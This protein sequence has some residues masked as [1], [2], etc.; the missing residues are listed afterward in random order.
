MTSETIHI[1]RHRPGQTPLPR[2][3]LW[4]EFGTVD[5]SALG[6]AAEPA[7]SRPTVSSAGATGVGIRVSTPSWVLF[8]GLE[9]AASKTDSDPRQLSSSEVRHG[10]PLRGLGN[11]SSGSSGSESSD[12]PLRCLDGSS[13]I[14]A[15]ALRL[16]S[17]SDDAALRLLRPATYFAHGLCLSAAFLRK[18][19]ASR[20]P[21]RIRHLGFRIVG[22]ESST[23]HLPLSSDGS[24]AI[25]GASSS[26][27]AEASER[28]LFVI[29]RRYF[30]ATASASSA[31]LLRK[32]RRPYSSKVHSLGG[33]PQRFRHPRF[34]G[35]VGLR[36]HTTRPL[37]CPG[38]VP[39][40]YPARAPRL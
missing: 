29:L 8:G 23:R 14:S 37:H 1:Q 18:A 35:L 28:R 34:S 31:A 21:P 33:P 5:N 36:S 16:S 26:A 20:S 6:G 40:L 10:Q 24:P 11:P 25:Y 3:K 30:S 15:R 17:R 32:H 39:R 27:L 9:S 13:I 38:T 2:T 4:H 19:S 22:S 7:V 12:R